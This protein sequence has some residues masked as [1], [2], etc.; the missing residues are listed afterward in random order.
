MRE[1]VLDFGVSDGGI[2]FV[3]QFDLGGVNVQRDDFVMLREEY[4]I[5]KAD[6]AGSSDSNSIHR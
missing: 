3:D 6:V 4:S 1:V 5:G 2:A